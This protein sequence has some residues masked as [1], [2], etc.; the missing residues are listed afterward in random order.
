[1]VLDGVRV[2]PDRRVA[3]WAVYLAVTPVLVVLYCLAPRTGDASGVLQLVLYSGLSLSAA[4]ALA[5]GIRRH[6]P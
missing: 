3:S 4:V 6:K 1:M 2:A 5:I